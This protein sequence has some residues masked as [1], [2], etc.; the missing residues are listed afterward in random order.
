MNK[1]IGYFR[2]ARA[3]LAKVIFPTKEQVQTAFI[4]VGSVVFV[5]LIF[6]A[7]VDS[8]MSFSISKFVA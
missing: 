3:E 2:L 1:L 6:I 8:L 4:A 5:V 7:L